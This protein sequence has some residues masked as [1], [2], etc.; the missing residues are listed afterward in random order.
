MPPYLLLCVMYQ[1]LQRLADLSAMHLN[2]LPGKVFP[3]DSSLKRVIFSEVQLGPP[4]DHDTHEQS[5]LE[6]LT[7]ATPTQ[8]SY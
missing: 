7:A 5:A 2:M 3:Y 4:Q 8:R 6:T 1:Q